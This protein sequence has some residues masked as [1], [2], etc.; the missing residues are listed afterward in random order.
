MTQVENEKLTADAVLRDREAYLRQLYTSF[1]PMWGKL[2][3]GESEES[4]LFELERT[5]TATLSGDNR[6]ARRR[7][8]QEI[9][10][11][12]ACEDD[13]SAVVNGEDDDD[14]GD[15]NKDHHGKTQSQGQDQGQEKRNADKNN[16]GNGNGDS[17]KQRP[18]MWWRGA[19]APHIWKGPPTAVAAAAGRR[20]TPGARFVPAERALLDGL[21]P[22]AVSVGRLSREYLALL[23]LPHE[24]IRDMYEK[25]SECGG[26][27]CLRSEPQN[28]STCCLPQQSGYYGR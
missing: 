5:K 17:T 12:V 18:T 25:V 1:V 21:E 11:R 27:A 8:K 23:G 20:S 13:S 26:S 16:D 24:S 15:A 3:D 4:A 9:G 7:R 22:Q 6:G 19:D 28:W 10:R 14:G 2:W